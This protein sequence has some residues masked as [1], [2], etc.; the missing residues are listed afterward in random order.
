MPRPPKPLTTAELQR[1]IARWD[2]GEGVTD[3]VRA[4]AQATQD[5]R[6]GG[7]ATDG[8]QA[9]LDFAREAQLGAAASRLAADPKYGRPDGKRPREILLTGSTGFFGA[10]LLRELRAE[11]ARRHSVPAAER[12]PRKLVQA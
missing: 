3:A 2:N 9:P 4:F 6:A 10:H 5:A 12:R 8:D 11:Q 1:I 7:L